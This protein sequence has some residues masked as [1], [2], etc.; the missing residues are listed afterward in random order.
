MKRWL[1]HY[2]TVHGRPDQL[3]RALRDH[4]RDLLAQIDEEGGER[5]T[6]EGDLLIAFPTRVLG[7]DMHKDVRLHTGVA[8]RR[9]NRTC[10][11][12]R[13]A[14]DPAR[15]VF[16]SFEGS[17]E[18]EPQSSRRATV[19]VVG[20]AT[21]PLGVVGAAVDATVLPAV[22]DRALAH[23]THVVA[24]GLEQ[25]V[26]APTTPPI[27]HRDPRHLTVGDIMTADPLV[28]HESMPLRTA[29]L[30]LFHYD[31][32]GAPVTNDAGGLVG[33]ISETDLLDI[34]APP[35]DGLGQRAA[36]SRRRQAARAVG[37]ACTRPAR[38]I[39]VDAMVRDA[40]GMMRDHDIGRLVVVE[41]SAIHGV[42]SRHDVLKALLR[43]D[44]D[45]QGAVDRAL[46][47]YD[48][49]VDA[50]VRWGVAHLSGVVPA[51]TLAAEIE[52]VVDQIDG[53][54]E[55]VSQLAWEHD[56]TFTA[57]Q[58]PPL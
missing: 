39:A 9:G 44:V 52:G 43:S 14:A 48:V 20:A 51:R 17:I 54:V 58:V 22:V 32:A 36:A 40:A 56:D 46:Q 47:A 21:V 1:Y 41:G 23:V 31:V 50:E 12:V 27:G 35:A 8:E 2:E 11:P 16:P 37:D 4:A 6:P 24:T 13:W 55:V 45:T 28:V 29:A 33:V 53:V 38:E 49:D 10:V 19:A 15:H 57:P 5:R 30:L 7:I 26:R 42:V 3:D 34:E 18:L 25:Q